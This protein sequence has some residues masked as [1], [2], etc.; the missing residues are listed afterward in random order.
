MLRGLWSKTFTIPRRAVPLRAYQNIIEL[1]NNTYRSCNSNATALEN[2]SWL[3]SDRV[4]SKN[5]VLNVRR[6]LEQ[7]LHHTTVHRA[8]RSPLQH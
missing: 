7:N 6:V 1:K 3:K 5:H 4:V 8:S 2:I